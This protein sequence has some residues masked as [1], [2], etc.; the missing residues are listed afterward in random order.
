LSSFLKEYELFVDKTDVTRVPFVYA[1]L[2]I[3]GESGELIE[4][5]KKAVRDNDGFKRL[6]EKRDDIKSEIG[7][8]FWSLTRFSNEMGF[9][10]E[11]VLEANM[12]K[13][14]DRRKNGKK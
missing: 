13:L 1:A 2:G 9:T 3:A 7:D 11:E 10:L 14:T 5:V 4:H 6:K 8:V 12:V